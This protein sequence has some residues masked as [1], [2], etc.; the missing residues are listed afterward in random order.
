[1]TENKERDQKWKRGIE[2]QQSLPQSSLWKTVRAVILP[3]FTLNWAGG[4][5]LDPTGQA[6]AVPGPEAADSRY[7]WHPPRR[8]SDT[9]TRECRSPKGSSE[10]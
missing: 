8:L 2:G 10:L 4:T 1:M 9:R 7:R 5:M 6:W 3:Q